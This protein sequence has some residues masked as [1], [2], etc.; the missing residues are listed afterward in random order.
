[1]KNLNSILAF[2]RKTKTKVETSS[3]RNLRLFLETLTKQDLGMQRKKE[4]LTENYITPIIPETIQS[5]NQWRKLKFV[6][7]EHFL[8]G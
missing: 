2:C 5:I 7:E 6:H 4:N 8:K 1:M 3:L